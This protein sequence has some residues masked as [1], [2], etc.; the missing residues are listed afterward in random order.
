MFAIPEPAVS[1]RALVIGAGMFWII[2][3]MILLGRVVW[4]IEAV[5]PIHVVMGL[6]G[7]AVGILK[8]HYVFA[9]VV[10]RNIK[11]IESL[12][13]HKE[14]ICLFAFQSLQSYLF[15]VLM[16]T[17]GVALRLTP[18]PLPYLFGIYVAIGLGLEISAFRYFRQASAVSNAVDG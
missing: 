18:I 8:A 1:R 15:V 4:F 16:V 11:R 17:L 12:S 3:G 10:R 2:G 14:K 5:Q 9:R 6:L 7:V 13:P